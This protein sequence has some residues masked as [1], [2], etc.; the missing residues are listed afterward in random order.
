MS[1]NPVDVI[2][3]RLALDIGAGKNP[4][5]G[6]VGVDRIDFGNGNVIADLTQRWP[7]EDSSVDEVHASHI[8]EHFTARQ[9]VHVCNELYRVLKPKA[10]A[11]IVVPH[12][13]SC[14]AYGDMTHQWPP[15]SEFWFYY[16]DKGWRKAN[17]PH[18]DS[19]F[20]PDGYSCDF[21][22]MWGN[23]MNPALAT[24]NPEYQQAAMANW[25]EAILDLHATL[26]CRK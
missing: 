7:W 14:R 8:I 19:E 17:A 20:S 9:R 13:A 23:A 16:L 25:K 2:Q 26:E 5:A 21:L 12:W 4:K 10:K 22:A 1:V 18:D 6:F 15:V 11:T 3:P 24:R